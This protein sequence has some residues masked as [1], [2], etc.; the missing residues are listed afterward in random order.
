VDRR[1]DIRAELSRSGVDSAVHY[2]IPCHKQ[3]AYT[4]FAPLPVVERAAGRILSLPLFPH[5]TERQVE[6]VAASLNA[7]VGRRA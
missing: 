6:H 3:P 4:A 5:I 2:P 1:D 7:A